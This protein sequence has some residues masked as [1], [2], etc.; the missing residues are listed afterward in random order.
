MLI[1]S[2]LTIILSVIYILIPYRRF[3]AERK[4]L[5]FHRKYREVKLWAVKKYYPSLR[6]LSFD[7]IE[8]RYD[9]NSI[10]DAIG[11]NFQRN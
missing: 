7:E 1:L 6:A 9:L 4:H 11:K 10:Y 3:L 8:R 2:S 5:N